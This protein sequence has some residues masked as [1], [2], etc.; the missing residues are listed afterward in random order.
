MKL[1]IQIILKIDLMKWYITPN[2]F[3][4]RNKGYYPLNSLNEKLPYKEAKWY[5]TIVEFLCFQVGV[6]NKT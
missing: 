2:V 1:P 6:Y 5:Y 4:M 3:D